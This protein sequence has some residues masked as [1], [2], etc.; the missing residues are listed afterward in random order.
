MTQQNIVKVICWLLAAL[1][2]YAGIQKW[3]EFPVFR[4]QIGSMP[5]PGPVRSAIVSGL[6]VVEILAAILL[7]VPRWRS[8][9][10]A[11]GLILLSVF[12][13]YLVY[14]TWY[15]EGL[16]CGCGG[17]FQFITWKV[18]LFLNILLILAALLGFRLKQHMSDPHGRLSKNVIS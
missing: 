17:V 2:L 5:F 15:D 1:F 8:L 10:L 4:E 14:I 3:L 7:I 12:T 13:S 6:P 11:T 16:T 18:H 9:G